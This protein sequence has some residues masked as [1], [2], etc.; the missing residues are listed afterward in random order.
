MKLHRERRG[1]GRTRGPR[2]IRSPAGERIELAVLNVLE[3]MV[4][5]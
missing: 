1:I 2:A 3:L 5:A 4:N